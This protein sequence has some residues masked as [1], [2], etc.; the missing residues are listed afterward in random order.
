MPHE[1]LGHLVTPDGPL[2]RQVT[3]VAHVLT[4]VYDIASTALWAALLWAASRL[5]G[6]NWTRDLF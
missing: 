4:S 6:V 5:S 1:E 3:H 2:A